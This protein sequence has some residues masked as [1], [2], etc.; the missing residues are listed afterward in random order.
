MWIPIQNSILYDDVSTCTVSCVLTRFAAVRMRVLSDSMGRG[1]LRRRGGDG[2]GVGGTSTARVARVGFGVAR[3]GFA[4]RKV[5]T[6]LRS[7]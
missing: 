2:D 3:V 4:D 6:S 1:R 7:C 5:V